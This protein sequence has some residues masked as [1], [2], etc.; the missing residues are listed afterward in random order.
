MDVTKVRAALRS[1]LEARGYKVSSDSVSLKGECYIVG[2]DD[3]ARALFDFRE[4]AGDATELYQGQWGE[5]MPPRFVV[6]PAT[7]LES[8]FLGLLMQMRI[9]PILC[10]ETDEGATFLMLDELLGQLV[11]AA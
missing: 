3:K 6:L 4:R 2:P 10:E 7:E 8:M 5:N 11:G 1:E 9:V